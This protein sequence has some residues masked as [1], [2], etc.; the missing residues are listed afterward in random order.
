M[1]E[2]YLMAGRSTALLLAVTTFTAASWAHALEGNITRVDNGTQFL[3]ELQSWGKETWA[4]NGTKT[5]ALP[6]GLISL[7]NEAANF[8][9]GKT[10]IRDGALFINGTREGGQLAT[11][12]DLAMLRPGEGLLKVSSLFSLDLWPEYAEMRGLIKFTNPCLHGCC[13]TAALL[14]LA[15]TARLFLSDLIIINR[16]E[17]THTPQCRS[18]K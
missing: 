13:Y 6:Q 9:A 3:A 10:L 4:N 16:C 18:A 17:H 15:G 1:C 14:A 8:T 7:Q 2:H 12:L 5:L 11:V